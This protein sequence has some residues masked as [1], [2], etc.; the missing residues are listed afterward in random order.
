MQ[1]LNLTRGRRAGSLEPTER[2]V[3]GWRA[4]GF[5]RPG[6]F[7]TGW[8]PVEAS[9]GEPHAFEEKPLKGGGPSFR[10]GQG[11]SSGADIGGCVVHRPTSRLSTGRAFEP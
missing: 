6:W 3:P 11:P 2:T 8:D 7:L 5:G 10:S 1:S 4:G 9:P